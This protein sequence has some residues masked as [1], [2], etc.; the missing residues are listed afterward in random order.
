[1]QNGSL[2]R[3]PPYVRGAGLG[4]AYGVLA[5]LLGMSS[6]FQLLSV[7]FILLVPGTMGYLAVRPLVDPPWS[8]RIWVSW[9]PWLL[10][11]ALAWLVGQEGAICILLATPAALV[12]AALGGF[13]ADTS[14]GRSR[15]MLPILLALPLAA[16]PI[17]ARWEP[18]TELRLV[19]NTMEIAAPA[20]VVWEHIR[21][22]RRI[23]RAE[24]GD[25]FFNVIGFPRPLEAK[26]VG[27]GVGA[28]REASFEGGVLFL[29]RI[30]A[31]QEPARLAFEI[32]AN[33]AGIPATTLDPHVV[34]GSR[35]FDVLDGEYRIEEARP[36]VTR[37]WLSSHHRLTTALA[38]YAHLWSDAILSS[39]QERILG[40][41]RARCETA[42]LAL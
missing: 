28:L 34:V 33:T 3:L 21:E 25:T 30:T 2:P 39:V 19:Q 16:G 24:H 7:A 40:V 10:A 36:G 35:Y 13:L 11:V 23:S 29:E 4:L 31:W 38:P 18:A 42:A 12:M 27:S 1:V 37:V 20:Q 41:I 32:H 22:V 26:L 9:V 5:R 14:V 17:E 8:K 15:P 6:L